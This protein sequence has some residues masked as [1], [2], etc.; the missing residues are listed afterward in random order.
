M[1]KLAAVDNQEK[2]QRSFE[3]AT[4]FGIMTLGITTRGI[5]DLIATLNIMTLGIRNECS[6]AE[7]PYVE[8]SISLLFC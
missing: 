1:A 7:Y 3:G 6:N 8:Y 4:T 2:W 5:M